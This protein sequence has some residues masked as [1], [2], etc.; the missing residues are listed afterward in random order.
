MKVRDETV[1]YFAFLKIPCVCNVSLRAHGDFAA[2]ARRF[3]RVRMEIIDSL[4]T[5]RCPVL[6]IYGLS[7]LP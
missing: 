6:M 7:A 2:C 3:C 4:A 1:I 5:G